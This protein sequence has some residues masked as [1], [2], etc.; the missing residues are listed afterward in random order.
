MIKKLIFTVFLLFSL[1]IESNEEELL[2]YSQFGEFCTMCEAVL[3]CDE[4]D[5]N[6]HS[7]IPVEGKFTL[8]HL[9]TRTFWSQ[10]ATIWEFFIK[11]FEGYELKGHQRPVIIISVNG[12]DWS[13][14][15]LSKTR[16]SID[17]DFIF[18][19]DAKINRLNNQW[20]DINNK[21]LGFCFR[22]PLWESIETINKR[23]N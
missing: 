6:N 12:A 3:L 17:P 23:S 7:S 2:L 16:I 15:V 22:L 9:K 19:N 21:A 14:A 5:K 18:F 13:E 4:G 1:Q 8:Y 20:L 10:I 11:N